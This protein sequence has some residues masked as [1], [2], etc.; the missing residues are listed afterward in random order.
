MTVTTIISSLIYAFI[1]GWKLTLLVLAFIP[2]IAIAAGLQMKVFV[3]DDKHKDEMLESG[4]V[5]NKKC[6]IFCFA[7]LGH[8][9]PFS[10]LP[11]HALP[12]LTLLSSALPFPTHP[13]SDKVLTMLFP[14][15]QHFCR[16]L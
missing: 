10:A 12:C 11:C 7:L 5:N 3:G 16:L 6:E 14:F 2:F 15:C 4:K 1:N 8:A 13:F 9:L